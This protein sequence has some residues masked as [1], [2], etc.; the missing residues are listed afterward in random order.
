MHGNDILLEKRPSNGIWGGLWCPPQ[1]IN[2]AAAL[3]WCA[4][5]RIESV[6]GEVSNHERAGEEFS[7]FTHTFTHFK[8][9]I[10]PVLLRLKHKP[11][12]VQ[13]PG[14]MW[15]DMEEALR[16]AIPSPVRRI[17][18]GMKN[19][20]KS[21]IS[22]THKNNWMCY[23][24]ECVDGTLYC[25]ITN[26]L[27]KRL[28]SHNAGE[29][30]KYTRGRAPVKL[31]YVERCANKSAALKREMEIKDLPRAEKLILCGLTEAVENR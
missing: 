20:K 11:Q 28:A 19:A 7:P 27:E 5:R 18:A 26:E 13:Q 9:H 6:S 4:Q 3:A 1:F 22:S 31:V 17:L 23:L 25:G 10:T 12:Q 14:S 29:G 15:L 30:A 24:L 2:K 8:L 21:L 16:G